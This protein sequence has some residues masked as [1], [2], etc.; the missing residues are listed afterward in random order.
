[1]NI[2]SF[3]FVISI[4]FTVQTVSAADNGMVSIKSKFGV[5]HTADRLIGVVKKKGLK[6]FAHIKHS[7]GAKKAGVDIRPTELVIF[8]NPKL[9]SPMIKCAPTLAID[10]PQKMLIWQDENEQTWMT[11][12][13][14]VYIA[15]RHE[16]A[17]DCRANLNKIAGALAKFTAIASGN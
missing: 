10:L 4:A 3:L 8:G 14:P 13:N 5:T 7:E 11:Y 2:K 12:N 17:A 1:M 9:G 6:V 16:L 15:D